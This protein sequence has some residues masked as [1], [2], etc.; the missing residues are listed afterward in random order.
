[1][2]YFAKLSWLQYEDSKNIEVIMSKGNNVKL[3]IEDL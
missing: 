3:R 2:K 1:M